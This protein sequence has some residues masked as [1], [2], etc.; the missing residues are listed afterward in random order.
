MNMFRCGDTM[1]RNVA[2]FDKSLLS[3]ISSEVGARSG[4]RPRHDSQ[5]LDV[6]MIVL[7]TTKCCTAENLYHC[8]RYLVGSQERTWFDV[9]ARTF[10]RGDCYNSNKVSRQTVERYLVGLTNDDKYSINKDGKKMSRQRI[11][12]WAG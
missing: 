6:S 1:I 7:E 10:I 4:C 5:K 2:H 8:D 12:R 9:F 11:S 3:Y